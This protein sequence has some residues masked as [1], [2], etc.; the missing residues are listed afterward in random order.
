[1][2]SIKL[3]QKFGL[4]LIV[5]LLF[6]NFQIVQANGSITKLGVVPEDSSKF[7]VIKGKIIDYSTRKTIAYTNIYLKGT[8]IGT[9]SNSE[10][11]FLLKIPISKSN[12]PIRISYMGYKSQDLTIDQIQLQNNLIE[13][14]NEVITLKELIIR[15]NDPQNLIKS[16]LHN[17]PENYGTSPYIC[18]AFYRESVMQNKQYVGLAE[19]VLNIYKSRYSNG[20]ESDRVKVFKGRKSQDVKRMDTILFKMQ[21][22]AQAVIL[23][24]LAKNPETF[25]TEEYFSNYEY[26]PV[27]ITNIEGRET[28]VVEFTQREGLQE[29]YYEGKLF[30]DVNSLAIRRAEFCIS[31]YGLQFANKYLV[32][33]KPIGTD[34]K[35]L[36]ANYMVN[37]R[38]MDGKWVLNHARYEVKF[39]VIKKGK[40]FNK[41][42]TSAADLAITDIDS[43]NVEKFRSNEMLKPNAIFVDQVSDYYDE[44]F[45]GNFNIIKPEESIEDAVERISKKMKKLSSI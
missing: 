44:E 12:Y 11:E 5:S 45:W 15:T 28:Y 24:D 13:L 9:I 19:A 25:M 40:L 43:K 4:L 39:R 33:K 17:V 2:K 37:Y 14:K 8:N 34:V 23:L 29:P 41:I 36:S 30:I 1:M 18:T 7:T 6:W 20:F 27:N 10:G 32:R 21:G 3:I 22:G 35:T 31:P 38:E 26:K 42:Y 16:A